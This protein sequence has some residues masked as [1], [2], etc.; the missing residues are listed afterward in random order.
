MSADPQTDAAVRTV[1]D[2]LAAVYVTRDVAELRAVFAAD[3]SVVMFSPGAPRIVGIDAIVDKAEA[4]WQR[5]DSAALTYRDVTVTLA[6]PVAWAAVDADFTV[7]AGD[8]E[9]TMPAHITFILQRGDD[10]RIVHAH[11]S[12]GPA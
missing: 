3:P 9:T 2:R 6:D 11:Y 10:W 4:D 1:L 8:V 12:L 7:R 5:S